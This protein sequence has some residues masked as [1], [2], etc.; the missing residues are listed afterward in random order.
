MPSSPCIQ[1]NVSL[2]P[3]TTLGIGGAARFFVE[4]GSEDELHATLDFAAQRRLPVFILG[5]GSN[6]LI[7]D[8]GF[9]G[10]VIRVA[11]KGIVWGE[12]VTVGA[13]ESWDDFVGQ[14]VERNLAGIE[15]LSGI[16]GSVGGTP[17]QNVGAYGQ[18]VSETIT[19]VRALDRLSNRIV[20][21]S[22]ADCRFGYRT[23]IFNS[24]E[25]DRYVVLAV[26]YALRPAG[27]PALRY[28]DLKNFF[29]GRTDR[30][31]LNEVRQAVIAIRAQ[32]GMVI[33]PNDPNCR[34]AGSFFKNPVLAVE[35]FARLEASAQAQGLLREG[36][37]LPHFSAADGQIKVPAAWLIERAGFQKGYAKGQAGISS[38][39][40][41]AII[42]RGNATAREVLALVQEIQQRTAARFGVQLT[43]EPVFVGFSQ[44]QAPPAF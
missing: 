18:E 1:E 40:T 23:G 24:T 2:A 13:G 37:R 21:L 14:C 11:L 42:N 10:L 15:C 12:Q 20:E 34:S 32:K 30:P 33:Q 44:L 29:A 35:D 16:P 28:P 9:P 26:T 4:V 41:L 5:G 39:H 19:K 43:P 8:E 38:K 7:A 31:T 6:L 22:N 25:R 17:V 27:E 3:L 36:E